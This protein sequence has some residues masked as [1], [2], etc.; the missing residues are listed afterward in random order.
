MCGNR[1]QHRNKIDHFE[2]MRPWE[3]FCGLYPFRSFLPNNI[4]SA[5]I[6]ALS[7]QF[8]PMVS[9]Q[10]SFQQTMQHGDDLTRNK[11]TSMVTLRHTYKFK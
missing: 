10:R 3:A 6:S 5:I 7:D 8:C 1:A 9:T 4:D 11:R 2:S